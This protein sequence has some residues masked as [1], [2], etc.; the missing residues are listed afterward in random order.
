MNSTAP[1]RHNIK[2]CPTHAPTSHWRTCQLCARKRQAHIADVAEELLSRYPS[3]CWITLEPGDSRART[4]DAIRDAYLRQAKTEAGIWT[5]EQGVKT[6]IL[7][8]NIITHDHK[9]P[10]TRDARI[11]IAPLQGSI[12]AVAAYISKRE[13]IPDMGK[14]AGRVYG[15]WGKLSSWLAAPDMPPVP[16]AAYLHDHVLKDWGPM[17]KA[18]PR[19]LKEEPP[20]IDVSTPEGRS[21]FRISI[22]KAIQAR[23]NPKAAASHEITLAEAAVIA[24]DRLPKL[25]EL[26]DE[27]RKSIGQATVQK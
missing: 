26:M 9:I 16:R 12:R 20:A 2:P 22:E 8:A 14:F 13:Q 7:H 27:W 19:W 11:H 4:I 17:G 10:A 18:D 1:R 6:G 21:A 3:L 25:R 23:K 24:R 5:I 15:R